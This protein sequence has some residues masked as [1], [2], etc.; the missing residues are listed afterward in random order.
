MPSYEEE[1]DNYGGGG[2]EMGEQILYNREAEDRA[3]RQGM[4]SEESAPSSN[5]QDDSGSRGYAPG[6]GPPQ[7]GKMPPGWSQIGITPGAPMEKGQPEGDTRSRYTVTR[8]DGT[9]TKVIGGGYPQ[10]MTS[11]R[12]GGRLGNLFGQQ[13]PQIPG[14]V[15]LTRAENMY[16]QRLQNM[17]SNTQ[18]A[19]ASG[20]I[21]DM[22]AQR[23]LRQ[24]GRRMRPLQQRND[25]AQMQQI[26]QQHQ[27]Q[28]SMLGLQDGLMAEH[29]KH[30]ARSA[31]DRISALPVGVNG[32]QHHYY[33]D[34]KGNMHMLESDKLAMQYKMHQEKLKAE[35]AHRES[36]AAR[37][38][39]ESLGKDYHE[40]F[41][42]LTTKKRVQ[43]DPNDA[44]KHH[45]ETV[46]PEHDAVMEGVLKKRIGT[47]EGKGPEAVADLIEK[48][49][50]EESGEEAPQ[51]VKDKMRSAI[52][53]IKKPTKKKAGGQ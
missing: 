32:E 12:Y 39:Q 34:D 43:D 9:Q 14:Q 47:A 20:E 16:L 46:F 1:M 33:T 45:E 49:Y 40:M 41:K 22:T 27:K 44:T 4:S 21:D 38:E 25:Q 35:S 7:G 10:G 36:E 18:Q 53:R 24:I 42:S 29:G 51:W 48:M 23:M 26:M 19:A 30:V 50:P 15:G 31:A 11:G 17:Q 37:H 52:R 3:K 2:M 28:A 5:G 13:M 6:A 8:E